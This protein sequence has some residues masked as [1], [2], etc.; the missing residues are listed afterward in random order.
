M[1]APALALPT[2]QPASQPA[3]GLPV[4]TVPA[5]GLALSTPC[6]VEQT[7]DLLRL[8]CRRGQFEDAAAAARVAL[9]LAQPRSPHQA[10]LRVLADAQPTLMRSPEESRL[11][12]LR[13]A[14]GVLLG[15]LRLR[16][17]GR[18]GLHP[19]APL[20][21]WALRE[22]RLELLNAAGQAE[23]RFSLCGQHDGRRLYLGGRAAD[24]A[25]LLL[26]EVCCLFTRL[27][28]LDPEL[29]DPFC[30][31]YEIDALVPA[32]LPPRSALLLGSPHSGAAALAA[33]LNRQD[34]LFFDGELLHPQGIRL[35]EGSLPAGAGAPL[36]A[37]RAKDPI[38]FAC[39][40]LGRSIDS[41]GRDLGAAAVRGFTLAPQHSAAALDWAVREPAL[42][43]V[44]VAR[45][46]LLAEFADILAGQPGAFGPDGRLSFE[47]ERFG[48][49]VEMQQR[50]LD[51]MRQ[52]LM[53]RSGDTVEVDGSR[54]NAAT[55]R[56]LTGFLSDTADPELTPDSAP[57]TSRQRVADRFDQP[58]AVQACLAALGR[59]GW[60]EVEG[61]VL[62]PQ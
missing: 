10:L 62:D 6:C 22:G 8:A 15:R 18:L 33:A 7:A 57:A 47:P 61:T 34:G 42:R 9:A 58:G 32:D 19:P 20:A 25:P 28:A 38:W 4:A 31:L 44:H 35:A 11:Y 26:Q 21:G 5:D 17:N 12:L 49:Y 51:A 48:R 14:D 29:A 39:M 53:Q 36:L 45:S 13:G 59:P 37:M 46:N 30:G 50:Y 52:R 55:L 40:V 56:E 54:L 16:D 1:N 27:S 41:Q 24:G 2:T 60:A 43:I 3:Q 23:A